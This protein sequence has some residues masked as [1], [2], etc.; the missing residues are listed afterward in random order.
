M[1]V[2]YFRATLALPSP[3]AVGLDVAAAGVAVAIAA[4]LSTAASTSASRWSLTPNA[5]PS[6][7]SLPAHIAPIATLT[8]PTAESR[9][10]A[11]H[12]ALACAV[13]GKKT[14]MTVYVGENND[15][16]RAMRKLRRKMIGEGLVQGDEGI[17]GTFGKDRTSGWRRG[18]CS[19]TRRA[20]RC[21]VGGWDGSC[22]AGSAG[23]S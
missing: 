3:H 17:A 15:V 19:S 11:W 16:D 9:F 20:S 5:A 1:R 8:T 22:T 4:V 10:L 21:C 18:A 2:R 12:P 23:S 7:P 6:L 14:G 13:R